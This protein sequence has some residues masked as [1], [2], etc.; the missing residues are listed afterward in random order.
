[1]D[2][3]PAFLDERRVLTP[4]IARTGQTNRRCL[5]DRC[6][7][8]DAREMSGIHDSGRAENPDKH[9]GLAVL[10]TYL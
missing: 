3:R 5:A 6:H 2:S 7:A 1:M 9:R 8:A 10:C 4:T